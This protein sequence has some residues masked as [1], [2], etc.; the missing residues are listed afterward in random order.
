[1]LVVGRLLALLVLGLLSIAFFFL[2]LASSAR[3]GAGG[4][5]GRRAVR[6]SGMYLAL[7]SVSTALAMVT[8]APRR[9]TGALAVLVLGLFG[10]AMHVACTTLINALADKGP[11]VAIDSLR[12]FLRHLLGQSDR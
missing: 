10:A 1:M 9:A 5:A 8:W 4:Q 2:G 11:R 6:F 3:Q 12:R 7:A